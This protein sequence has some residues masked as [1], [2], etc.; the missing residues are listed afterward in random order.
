MCLFHKIKAKD[1]VDSPPN[2]QSRHIRPVTDGTISS[3]SDALY[4]VYVVLK[5]CKV[6]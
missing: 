3:R 4:F 6:A 2:D 1:A 5:V